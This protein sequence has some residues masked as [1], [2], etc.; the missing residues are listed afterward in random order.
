MKYLVDT[1]IVIG[2]FRGKKTYVDFINRNMEKGLAVSIISY[3]EL[4]HG[5]QKSARPKKNLDLIK[6][7][8]SLPGISILLFDKPGAI[9]YGLLMAELE[10]GGIKLDPID[11]LIAATA[12]H[13]K[14][15]VVTADE[16]HFFRLKNFGVKI[17]LLA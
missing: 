15:T 5:A 17:E 11:L 2:F 14:L 10:K 7:F 3:A 12:G 13:H 1:N 8:F 9:K 4:I 6:Q 16:K